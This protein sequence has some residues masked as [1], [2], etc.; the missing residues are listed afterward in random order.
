MAYVW[1]K[2]LQSPVG[3]TRTS[4]RPNQLGCV[5]PFPIPAPHD[6]C[7]TE[8]PQLENGLQPATL[9]WIPNGLQADY[10]GTVTYQYTPLGQTQPVTAKVSFGVSGLTGLA[11]ETSV[12]AVQVIPGDQATDLEKDGLPILASAGPALLSDGKTVGMR[13]VAT[14]LATSGEYAWVQLVTTDVEKRRWVAG[15]QSGTTFTNPYPCLANSLHPNNCGAPELDTA[16]PYPFFD[17]PTLNPTVRNGEAYD[18]PFY[19]LG[20]NN[21]GEQ[22]RYFFA[23][24]YL[25]WNPN[26]PN[27]IP[28][29]VGQVSW[30]ACGDTINTLSMQQNR[31]TWNLQPCSSAAS[32]PQFKSSSSYP[33]WTDAVNPKSI[34]WNQ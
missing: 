6:Q 29:P 30:S 26:L 21:E 25:L 23:T 5:D 1:I 32:S 9:Y 19:E 4:V 15:S 10:V 3:H 8:P 12:G 14:S 27:S 17:S 11:V 20:F 7:G 2:R 24:M 31:S 18:T 16:Y 22:A 33:V 34:N 13:S 28:V